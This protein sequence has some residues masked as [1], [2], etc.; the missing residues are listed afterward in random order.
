MAVGD[1]AFV[2]GSEERGSQYGIA[3]VAAGEF[4]A[5][6]EGPEV[7]VGG[8]LRLLGDHRSP[9]PLAHVRIGLLEVDAERDAAA[10]R[11]IDR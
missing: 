1:R 3:D 9:Q 7:D 6:G 2:G 4:V 10:E 8:D 11:I 5:R